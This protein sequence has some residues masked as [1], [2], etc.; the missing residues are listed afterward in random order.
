MHKYGSNGKITEPCRHG[1]HLICYLEWSLEQPK[2]NQ[3]HNLN[4]PM[5]MSRFSHQIDHIDIACPGRPYRKTKPFESSHMACSGPVKKT[6]ELML[7]YPASLSCIYVSWTRVT[8]IVL[9]NP[10][11]CL[12]ILL[13]ST[14]ITFAN[15]FIF[16][17]HKINI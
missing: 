8:E 1:H 5:S 12:P 3:S 11:T 14:K 4:T 16:Y 15:Q 7:H 6:F 17:N 9:P 13:L 2:F 10:I